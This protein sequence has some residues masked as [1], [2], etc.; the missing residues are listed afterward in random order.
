MKIKEIRT[1]AVR[2]RGQTPFLLSHYGVDVTA[3]AYMGWALDYA[4]RMLPLLEPFCPGWLEE[5]V[6]PDDIRGYAELAALRNVEV[7]E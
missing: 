5:P 6:V 4:K 2:W 7:I 1:R 3:N